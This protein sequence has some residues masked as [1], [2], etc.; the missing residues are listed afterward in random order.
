M[1]VLIGIGIF[2]CVALVGWAL[3]ELKG[4][5]DT[6]QNSPEEDEADQRLADQL[7]RDGYEEKN[8]KDIIKTISTTGFSAV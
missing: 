5:Y 4:R 3:A 1:E 6:Y 2:V 8:I 7:A